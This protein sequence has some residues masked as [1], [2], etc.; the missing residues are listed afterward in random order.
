MPPKIEESQKLRQQ[1]EMKTKVLN[2]LKGEILPK[3][4]E[5]NK[6]KINRLKQQL[7]EKVEDCFK[8]ISSITELKIGKRKTMTTMHE[9]SSQQQDQMKFYD[10][11]I[12][13]MEDFFESQQKAEEEKARQK[14]EQLEEQRR[15][16]RQKDEEERFTRQMTI[17][18]EFEEKR[19]KCQME[20]QQKAKLP[21][22][23]IS[24]LMALSQIG[25]DFGSNLKRKSTN[26]SV[27]QP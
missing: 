23:Q 13:D 3:L 10:D 2:N 22:W 1:S 14:E 21:K 17:E 8:Y 5:G 15:Q 4:T 25:Y 12:D 24:N 7:Q 6:R 19:M 20:E 11:L 9:W 26:A 18:F 27:M 16:Q